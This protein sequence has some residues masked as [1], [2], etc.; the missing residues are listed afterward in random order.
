MWSDDVL[1]LIARTR[2]AVAVAGHLGMTRFA[3]QGSSGGGP[4]ALACAV[5]MPAL[6]DAR[7]PGRDARGH[8]RLSGW[9][10]GRLADPAV[11]RYIT[12][13]T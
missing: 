12:M 5:L 6:G 8:P 13:S 11:C 3:V 4:Y 1:D 2:D 7:T 10:Y 9:R